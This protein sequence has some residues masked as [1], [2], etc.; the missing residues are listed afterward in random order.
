MEKRVHRL[1]DENKYD[2]KQPSQVFDISDV[3]V[4]TSPSIDVLL[5][6]NQT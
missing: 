2:K 3:Y 4:F 1:W 6:H 5:R